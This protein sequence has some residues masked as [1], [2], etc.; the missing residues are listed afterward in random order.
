VVTLIILK[1]LERLKKF[2]PRRSYW[3]HRGGRNMKSM[4]PS[5]LHRNNFSLEL[6]GGLR[7]RD[8]ACPID[9]K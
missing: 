9:P 2:S 3:L 4:K 1:F 5:V 7:V 8:G 6:K